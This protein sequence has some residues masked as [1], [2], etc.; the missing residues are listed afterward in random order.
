[1]QAKP[2]IAMLCEFDEP[3][4]QA[5]SHAKFMPHNQDLTREHERSC[6][7]GENAAEVKSY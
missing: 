3:E 7:T 6:R 1:M 4:C 2:S 5:G